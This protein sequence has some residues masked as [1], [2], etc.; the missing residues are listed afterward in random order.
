[1]DVVNDMKV[2]LQNLEKPKNVVVN[3]VLIHLN[4]V[5]DNVIDSNFFYKIINLQDWFI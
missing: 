2:K 4:G 1:M 5:S 3:P